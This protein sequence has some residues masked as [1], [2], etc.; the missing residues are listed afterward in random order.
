VDPTTGRTSGLKLSLFNVRDLSQPSLIASQAIG[1]PGSE[2]TWSDAEWDHH[3]FGYFPELGV[4]AIPFQ[5]FLP[6]E[7]TGEDT[8]WRSVANL[9][10]YRVDTA[11]G[12][13]PLGAVGFD[14]FVSRS[15]RIGDVLHAIGDREIRSMRVGEVLTELGSVV[16]QTDPG[17]PW[18]ILPIPLARIG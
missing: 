14:S 6:S 5:G 10:V 4:V 3:A 9:S 15:V 13:R 8:P 18:G 7:S 2:W 12:F 16:I 1:A 11:E 17:S